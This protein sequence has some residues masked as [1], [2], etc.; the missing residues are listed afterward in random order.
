M[1]N[2]RFFNCTPATLQDKTLLISVMSFYKDF[3]LMSKNGLATTSQAAFMVAS[4][5]ICWGID[6]FLG[7]SSMTLQFLQSSLEEDH[8]DE[9]E[10]NIRRYFRTSFNSYYD[11]HMSVLP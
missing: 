2:Q 6:S 4:E 11:L 10:T 1:F 7:S 3:I 5:E 8:S 9:G